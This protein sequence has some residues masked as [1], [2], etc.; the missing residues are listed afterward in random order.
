VTWRLP[1]RQLRICRA[2]TIRCT[3]HSREDI[4]MDEEG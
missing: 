1:S 2:A 3:T 4:S